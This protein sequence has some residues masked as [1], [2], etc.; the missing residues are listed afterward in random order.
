MTLRLLIYLQ[1][2]QHKHEKAQL[3]ARSSGHD[4]ART[5][6]TPDT[7]PDTTQL[8]LPDNWAGIRVEARDGDDECI[9]AYSIE[10]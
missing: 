7:T 2:I 8:H 10:Y 6:T 9:S 5:D 4:I 3:W 1:S